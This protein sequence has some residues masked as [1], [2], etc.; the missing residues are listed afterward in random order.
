MAD[1]EVAKVTIFG[2]LLYFLKLM[3][4]LKNVHKKAGVLLTGQYKDGDL[5]LQ[6]CY[7]M[8]IMR[9]FSYIWLHLHSKF[10]ICIVL[11]FLEAEYACA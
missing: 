4:N 9:L 2:H 11:I 5:Y 6:D 7:W 3:K 10:S 8:A 1:L